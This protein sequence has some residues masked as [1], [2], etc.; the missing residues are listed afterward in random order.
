M[1]ISGNRSKLIQNLNVLK[2]IL[3]CQEPKQRKLQLKQ[4]QK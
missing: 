4:K 2:Y 1:V 3:E